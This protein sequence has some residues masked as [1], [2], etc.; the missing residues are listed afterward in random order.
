MFA[1]LGGLGRRHGDRRAGPTGGNRFRLHHRHQ[2]AGTGQPGPADLAETDDR[3]A[4]APTTIPSSSGRWS[5][6]R[7]PKSAPIPCWPRSA[8]ITTTSAR[9][10]N[11]CISSKTS[12]QRQNQ[13][14]K[15]APSMSR[16]ILIA[17]V[18][19]GV[20]MAR[21]Q[22]LGPGDRR[23]HPAVPRDQLDPLFLR[24][25][26]QAARAGQGE[27]RRLPLPGAQAPD[28]RSRPG[29]AGRRRRGGFAA[30][31]NPTPPASKD[32]PRT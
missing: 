30:L 15:L 17:H 21:E 19:D 6:R 22:K 18:K 25:G 8:A 27:P 14:D 24:K 3:C 12:P 13:H 10:K 2:T 23:H 1:A 5:R 4:R 7:P 9:S 28:P 20:K 16:T 29:H 11:R 31:D 32:W 26:P